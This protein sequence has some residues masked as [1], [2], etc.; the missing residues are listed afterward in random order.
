MIQKA[1]YNAAKIDGECRLLASVINEK[2]AY[3]AAKIGG[4]C[5]LLASA[6]NEKAAYEYAAHRRYIK[7]I[8]HSAR[9]QGKSIVGWYPT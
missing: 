7:K 8:P 9:E 3:N 2:A 1:A 5:R 4:E 6:I